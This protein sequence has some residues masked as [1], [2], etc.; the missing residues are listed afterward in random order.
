MF[1]S[2]RELSALENA[3][4]DA[5]SRVD[6]ISSA[7]PGPSPDFPLF[8]AFPNPN[9][10]RS[11]EESGPPP[12]PHTF[13][14][15]SFV[16][17]S[18]CR[19]CETTLWGKAMS[20]K[21]CGS[22]VHTKCEL[23]VPADCGNG[24]TTTTRRPLS[25]SS[26][27][28]IST[29]TQPRPL[30]TPLPTRG[31]SYTTAPPTSVVQSSIPARVLYDYTATTGFELTV[32]I[33]E[34]VIIVEEEDGEGWCK[35]T[36]DD[37]R[38]G[39]VPASYLRVGGGGGEVRRGEFLLSFADSGLEDSVGLTNGWSGGSHCDIRLRSDRIRRINNSRRRRNRIDRAGR[40]F[41]RRLDRG[42]SPLPSPSLA[43]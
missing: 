38:R 14:S 8:P 22:A 11:A 7:L 17:P 37:G 35:V 4:T 27:T 43:L 21:L 16:T 19:V 13:K 25:H 24:S 26:S 30:A 31:Q 1:E 41:R 20:C 33:D 18:T 29:T 36:T 10:L 40:R 12:T 15:A 39:L 23:L 6:L 5:R 42:T 9:S 28:S 3:H 32:H 34:E 2:G